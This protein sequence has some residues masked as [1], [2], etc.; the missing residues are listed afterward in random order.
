M[1]SVPLAKRK[2][3]F[4]VPEPGLFSP[5][6]LVQ[7][8]TVPV[9]GP[10]HACTLHV[11]DGLIVLTVGRVTDRVVEASWFEVRVRMLAFW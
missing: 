11:C 10:S 5:L 9:A 7:F 3:D 6:P 2:H 1:E 4:V 8:A